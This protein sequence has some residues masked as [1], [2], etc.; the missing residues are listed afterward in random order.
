MEKNNIECCEKI[1]VHEELL[2]IVQEKMPD[3]VKLYDLAEL[4]KR[5]S[6]ILQGFVSYLY[7]LKLKYVSVI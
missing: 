1:E 6:E 7:Y 5:S 4:F 3:E 2:K